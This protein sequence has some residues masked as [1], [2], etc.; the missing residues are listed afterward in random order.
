[1][2]LRH[3]EP[4]ESVGLTI[5]ST[6]R[7]WKVVPEKPFVCGGGNTCLGQVTNEIG[8]AKPGAAMGIVVSPAEDQSVDSITRLVPLRAG[9]GTDPSISAGSFSAATLIPDCRIQRFDQL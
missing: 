7:K 5:E 9:K 4:K 3:F 2:V 8:E 1:V 6:L